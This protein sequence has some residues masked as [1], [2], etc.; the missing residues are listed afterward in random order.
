M[1]IT[2]AEKRR[3]GNALYGLATTAPNEEFW[4]AV[5]PAANANRDAD[6]LWEQIKQRM[7]KLASMPNGDPDLEAIIDGMKAQHKA[8]MKKAILA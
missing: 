3:V 2:R 6:A 7:T 8:M 1:Y 5:D 4:K